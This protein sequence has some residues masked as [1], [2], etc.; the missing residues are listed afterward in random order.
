MHNSGEIERRILPVTMSWNLAWML[1]A[2]LPTFPS[3]MGLLSMLV[4]GAISAA[5][6]V[7]QTSSAD[8]S[9]NL[10]TS[11]SRTS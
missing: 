2:T 3:P 8:I 9:M 4:T 1:V 5:V 6:P 7:I 11:V 10:E